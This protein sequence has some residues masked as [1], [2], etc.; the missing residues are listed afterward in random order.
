[1]IK[2][3]AQ[4]IGN[5]V[6]TVT[7]PRIY[8]PALAVTA[9]IVFCIVIFIKDFTGNPYADFL[10]YEPLQYRQMTLRG[11]IH[12]NAERLFDVGMTAYAISNYKQAIKGLELAVAE[13]SDSWKYWMYL[14][15]SY[16]L[17]HRPPEAINALTK[18]DKLS[19]Y[20]FKDE[21]RW[22]LYQSLLLNKDNVRA[23]SLHNVL[24]SRG[25][26]YASIAESQR[27]RINDFQKKER[28]ENLA[29]GVVYFFI[30]TVLLIAW[31]KQSPC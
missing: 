25:G 15:I 10:S 29:L 3:L 6:E 1:M 14:G 31:R 9:T 27:T 18:A 21:I 2:S 17:D 26:K 28:S 12:S 16:Y 7:K 13:S 19:K 30:L 4:L 8:A 11:D 20:A 5:L 22:Y 24:M 23:D